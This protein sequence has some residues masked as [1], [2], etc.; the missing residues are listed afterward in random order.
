MEISTPN[1]QSISVGNPILV[2]TDEISELVR[3]NEAPMTMGTRNIA[4]YT[5]ASGDPG[6]PNPGD[7]PPTN[8]EEIDITI[9]EEDDDPG[10]PN[11]GDNPPTN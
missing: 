10:E 11:P 1:L 6:E 5:L 7:N 2:S 9:I 8:I 4:S 3:S